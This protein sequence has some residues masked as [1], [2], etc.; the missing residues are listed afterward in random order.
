MCVGCVVN[1]LVIGCFRVAWNVWS[2]NVNIICVWLDLLCVHMCECIPPL[3]VQMAWCDEG[4]LMC[5]GA[6]QYGICISH[7]YVRVMCTRLCLFCWRHVLCACVYLR[8][9]T[10]TCVCVSVSAFSSLLCTLYLCPVHMYMS[11]VCVC[12]YARFSCICASLNHFSLSNLSVLFCVQWCVY[13][14]VW[15]FNVYMLCV[16]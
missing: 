2:H 1:L 15:R 16:V 6:C 4:V 11:M 7:I 14:C 8:I 5:V 10:R 9:C 3:Y 13:E 12:V